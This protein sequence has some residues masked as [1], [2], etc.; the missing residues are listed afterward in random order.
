MP[1]DETILHVPLMVQAVPW[2]SSQCTTS[3]TC[4]RER[5]KDQF[6][7]ANTTSQLQPLDQDIIKNFKTFYRKEVVKKMIT[8]MEQNTVSSI[9]VLQAMRMVDKA[10]RNVTS[11][12]VKNCFKTCGFPVQMQESIELEGDKA[13]EE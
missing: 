4:R 8:D 9:N 13:P 6:L 1:P 12:A 5:V 3:G 7:P 10:W 11:N 2:D